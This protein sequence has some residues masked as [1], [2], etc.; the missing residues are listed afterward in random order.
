MKLLPILAICLSITAAHSITVAPDGVSISGPDCDPSNTVV[1]FSPDYSTFSILYS[2]METNTVG[3]RRRVNPNPSEYDPT[4]SV[5]A[6][7]KRCNV[8]IAF[9]PAPGKQLELQQ[10]EYRA[11]V[12]APSDQTFAVIESK[13]R[14][15]QG[16]VV[17]GGVTRNPS[18]WYIGGVTMAK[19]G[20]FV[21]E[22]EWSARF[23][24]TARTPD[25]GLQVSNCTGVADF[26]IE[27]T[28]RAH[29][30]NPDQD[31]YVMLDSADGT[32][33]EQ[34][35][36]YKIAEKNCDSTNRRRDRVCRNGRC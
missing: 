17:T 25:M 12:N 35:A 23:D 19:Q 20:P 34:S 6:P 5:F 22:L 31:V 16:S 11:Y 36:V 18:E 2:T 1:V 28:V 29:S 24:A 26:T 14:F 4:A 27:T 3:V 9:R 21:D 10:I 7:P 8:K 30:F 13:H 33:Q 32:F 15:L